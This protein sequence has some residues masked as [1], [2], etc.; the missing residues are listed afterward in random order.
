MRWMTK[1]ER[2]RILAFEAGKLALSLQSH[3]T[4]KEKPNGLGPVTN[5]DLEADLLIH[6]GIKE[7]FPSDTIV[8]EESFTGLMAPK[9]EEVWFI[10]PIDGT[11]SY[12]LGRTDFVVMIGLAHHGM[13]VLG[14]IYQPATDTMWSGIK[15]QSEDETLCEKYEQGTI[16]SIKYPHQDTLKTLTELSLMASRSSRSKRQAEF[17]KALQPK[18]VVY[19]GSVGLKAMM[20]LDGKA[21]LYVCWSRQIKMWD[22][23]AAAAIIAASG[24]YMSKIDG[25]KLIYEGPISHGQSLIVANAQPSEHLLSLLKEIDGQH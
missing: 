17:I 14:V 12:V 21:D 11:S 13:P 24:Y 6:E 16:T 5:G 10:D 18:N 4:V 25:S 23:C 15:G 7:S 3:L 2:A 8:S 22:T 1:L 19:Q 9:K 20:V